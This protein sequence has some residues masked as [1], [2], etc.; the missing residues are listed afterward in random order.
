MLV[1]NVLGQRVDMVEEV[2][3]LQAGNYRMNYARNGLSAGIYLYELQFVSARE[4][5]HRRAGKFTITR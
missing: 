2:R 4:R 5:R 1:Y 3:P